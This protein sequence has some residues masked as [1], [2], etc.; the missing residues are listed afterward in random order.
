MS[1][2]VGILAPGKGWGNFVSYISCFKTISIERNKKIILITK[3]FS[4]ARSYLKDQE[5]VKEFHEIPD[6]KRG[7]FKT[8]KYIIKLYKILSK[9]ELHEIFIFHSSLTLVLVS[10]LAKIKN[11]YAPGIRFQNFFLKKKNKL[12]DGFFSKSIEA[13]DE[14]KNLTKKI[15]NVD[16]I[17]FI[18]LKYNVNIDEKLVGICIACSGSEKQWG[19]E[20]YIKLINFL[21]ENQYNK[22]LLLSGKDQSNLENAIISNYSDQ[23]IFIDTSKKSIGEVIPDLKKCKF[24]IGNDTGFSHLS[25]AYNKKTYVILGDCPPHTYSNLIINIDKDEEVARSINSIQSIKIEKVLNHLS[26]NFT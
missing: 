7:F 12:Y 9:A 25:V 23:I 22:F 14:T 15:L 20:N 10:Y 13:V 16:N 21:I 5:F 2:N 8:I 6:N 11:I 4:S 1:H 18:P 24:V 17:E 19:K 26:K 3:K